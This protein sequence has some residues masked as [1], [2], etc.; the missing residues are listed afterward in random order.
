[1]HV[2]D[3]I[4]LLVIVQVEHDS[5][6]FGKPTFVAGGPNKLRQL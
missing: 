5:Q 1:M 4:S 6:T 2:D 3:L